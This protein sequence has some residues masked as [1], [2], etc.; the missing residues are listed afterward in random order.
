MDADTNLEERVA[1]KMRKL[2]NERDMLANRRNRIELRICEI[3]R[4]IRTQKSFA[5]VMKRWRL[6]TEYG[7]PPPQKRRRTVADLV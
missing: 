6:L 5:E 4:I 1:A 3:D 2:I 7:E